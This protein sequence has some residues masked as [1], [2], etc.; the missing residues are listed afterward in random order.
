MPQ[1]ASNIVELSRSVE[2]GPW[3]SQA[4]ILIVDDEP[5]MRNFLVKILTPRCKRVVEAKDVIEASRALD[6]E[7][8]D[9][10][11]LD[12]IMPGKSGVDWLNEQRSVGF[13]ADAI[14]ITAYADLET[15]IR[16]LQAGAV[17]FVLKPFRSNQILNAVA[18]CVDRLQLQ[19]ENFLLRHELGSRANETR[20]QNR[21]EG[22]SASI[23]QVRDTLARVAPMPTSVLITGESGTGKEVAARTLHASSER[24]DKPFVPV[25]CAAI[26]AEMIESELFGHVKGAFTGADGQRDGLFVHAN[27]G[28]LF[29]DEIGE[30]PLAMQTKLLR[31]IEDK[32]I[33]PV[34]AEREV[35]VDVRFVFATNVNLQNAVEA[36][37][38]RPDLYYRINILQIEMP[39]LRDRKD[40]IEGLAELFISSISQEL[41]VPPLELDAQTRGQF[42]ENDWPGNVRELRNR[43]ERSLILG[44]FSGDA[45]L[46]VPS[47]PAQSG[48]TLE[49][50]ERRHILSVLTSTG[51]NRAEAARRLGVSRKTIDRKCAQWDV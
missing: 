7:Q 37:A 6:N 9:V 13:F 14:L 26:P 11:I 39:P 49:A 35:P 48:Q 41:G 8:F 5:G 19:R 46:A 24:A 22:T 30:L 38:F 28:T 29:L 45:G 10:V 33:R 50:V 40:D 20:R 42:M 47:L 51:G 4:S 36:G 2:F 18:R 44:T 1:Q 17:D 34:G 31:V 25:N 23:Q 27:G 32:R 43:I 3:L 15:A 16:A 21:L 12:N